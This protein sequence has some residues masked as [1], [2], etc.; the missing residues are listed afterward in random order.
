MEFFLKHL[1]DTALI[2]A[3][4]EGHKEIVSL[5]LTQENIDVNRRDIFKSFKKFMKFMGFFHVVTILNDLWN[6]FKNI[7]I[8][9]H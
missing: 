9:Q 1:N 5:L 8:G 6:F 4:K 7:L 3:A 2:F